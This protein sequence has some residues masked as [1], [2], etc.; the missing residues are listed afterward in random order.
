MIYYDI[1]CTVF[2]LSVVIGSY[3]LDSCVYS[4]S[5]GYLMSEKSIKP[6]QFQLIFSA[7]EGKFAKQLLF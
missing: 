5:E 6:F 4:Y 2:S 1:L 3:W 7:S